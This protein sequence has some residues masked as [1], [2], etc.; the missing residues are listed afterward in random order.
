MIL[1]L[2]KKCWMGER[3]SEWLSV[4]DD[5]NLVVDEEGV[6]SFVKELAVNCQPVINREKS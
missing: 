6:L 4:D 2:Q 5:L 3:I 1:T